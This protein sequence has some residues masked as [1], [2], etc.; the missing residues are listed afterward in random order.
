[1]AGLPSGEPLLRELASNRLLLGD[2]AA[3]AEAV[4]PRTS[5]FT[6]QEFWD[7]CAWLLGDQNVRPPASLMGVGLGAEV[8]GTDVR[9]IQ[10]GDLD[11][12]AC[13]NELLAVLGAVFLDAA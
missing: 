12:D 10:L 13:S 2:K 4:A 9:P 3:F 11:M 6:R 8:T 5:A 1:M 7:L